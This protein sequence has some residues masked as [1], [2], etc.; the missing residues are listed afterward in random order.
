MTGCTNF[1]KIFKDE[2]GVP[3]LA[4]INSLKIERA[5]KLLKYSDMNISMLADSLKYPDIHSFS[6]AFKKACGC[7]PSKYR[8]D[9]RDTITF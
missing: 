2:V 7:S 6:R 5:Q 9:F 4:Y 1:I 8:D 3:P